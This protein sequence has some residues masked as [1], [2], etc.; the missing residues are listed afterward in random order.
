MLLDIVGFDFY[1]IPACLYWAFR[2]FS[3]LKLNISMH[4]NNVSI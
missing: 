3:N 1:F 4:T 2:M